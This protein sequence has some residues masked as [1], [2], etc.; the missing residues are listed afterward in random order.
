MSP[1]LFSLYHFLSSIL[2]HQDY[3]PD[4]LV[5]NRTCQINRTQL[6]FFHVKT[7]ILLLL[8]AVISPFFYIFF[9]YFVGDVLAI[10]QR[11]L[12]LNWS[13]C[14]NKFFHYIYCQCFILKANNTL[15]PFFTGLE[16]SY[17]FNF[18]IPPNFII[19][20]SMVIWLEHLKNFCQFLISQFIISV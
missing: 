14:H 9:C 13:F 18:K 19:F 20:S 1:I 4:R 7:K 6:L 11:I 16:C 10:L 12:L 15:I 5:I 17:R 3:P 2:S 8:N